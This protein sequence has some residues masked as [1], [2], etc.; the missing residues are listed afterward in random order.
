[1][2]LDDDTDP[3]IGDAK[4]ED[5]GRSSISS[6]IKEDD[7]DHHQE[8]MLLGQAQRDKS[9]PNTRD[10]QPKKRSHAD[11][12]IA[13]PPLINFQNPAGATAPPLLR[14]QQS[15]LL[16]KL[17]KSDRAPSTQALP[18]R[19]SIGDQN[20][21]QPKACA[22]QNITQH[23]KASFEVANMFMEVIVF[24][25][26]LSPIVSDDK[27][28]MVEDSWK[29]AIEAKDC[30]RAIAG[31]PVRMPS[32]SIAWRTISKWICKHQKL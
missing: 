21:P 13:H 28:S 20:V 1:L 23:Q 3:D 17:S 24:T 29:L 15:T 26:T 32:V 10:P 9:L 27:Y 7:L 18:L 5:P 16:N 11:T 2:K 14:R 4:S 25:K 8:V 30:Q 12:G 31:A 22:D 19:K 6:N